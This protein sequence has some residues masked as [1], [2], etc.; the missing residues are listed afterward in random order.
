MMNLEECRRKLLRPLARYNF[1]ISWSG[2]GKYMKAHFGYPAF[3]PGPS[4]LLTLDVTNTKHEF[5]CLHHQGKD[6]PD[7]GGS[8]ETLADVY[9]T[10]RRYIPEDSHFFRGSTFK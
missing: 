4:S 7:D 2:S 10:T 6:R 1:G 5:E 9:Q 8:K 3:K